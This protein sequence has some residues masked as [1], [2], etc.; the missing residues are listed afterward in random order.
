M[1]DSPCL[2]SARRIGLAGGDLY[3]G[4]AAGGRRSA[5]V[6]PSWGSW[7]VRQQQNRK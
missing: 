2:P 3:Q 4:V 7:Q 6:A 5:A 1:R